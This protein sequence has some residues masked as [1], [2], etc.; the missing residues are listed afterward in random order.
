LLQKFV[1]LAMSKYNDVVKYKVEFT[2]SQMVNAMVYARQIVVEKRQPGGN[3][4]IIFIQN[5]V[6]E[7]TLNNADAVELGY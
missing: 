3:C 1:A 2:V 4:K 5:A 7:E 6:I